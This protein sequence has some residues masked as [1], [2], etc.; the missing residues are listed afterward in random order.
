MVTVFFLYFPKGA[1]L[2]RMLANFMGHSVFQ[3]GLQVSK[4]ISDFV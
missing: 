4:A 2:I 1:A 3:M